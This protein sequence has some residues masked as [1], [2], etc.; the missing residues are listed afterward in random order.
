MVFSFFSF[1]KVKERT[2]VR[3]HA[4]T[5]TRTLIDVLLCP[6]QGCYY[7]VPAKEQKK[8]SVRAFNE[9]SF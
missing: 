1:L 2:G 5:H 6:V 8:G 4:H 3:T 9:P 7:V